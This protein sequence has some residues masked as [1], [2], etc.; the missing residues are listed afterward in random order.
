MVGE[1]GFTFMGENRIPDDIFK[2]AIEKAR[3]IEIATFE[4]KC[5]DTD[6]HTFSEKYL[7]RMQILK[8]GECEAND[9]KIV[10]YSV[11]KKSTKVKILLIAAIVMLLG[12]LT[13]T[14]E[15]VREVIYQLKEKIFPDNTEV[16]FQE[17]HANVET[18]NEGLTWKD[19]E[20]KKPAYIPSEYHSEVEELNESICEYLHIYVNDQ[21]KTITYEQKIIGAFDTWAISSDGDKAEIISINGERGYLFTDKKNYHTIV[22][23]SNG[24]VYSI[25]GFQDIDVLCKIVESI[26]KIKYTEIYPRKLIKVPDGYKLIVEEDSIEDF[27]LYQYMQIYQNEEGNNLVYQQNALDE[28]DENSLNITADGTPA[29][30]IAVCGEVAYLLTDYES[31]HT[32]IYARAGYLYMLGGYDEVDILI[33][34]LESVFEE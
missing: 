10:S 2:R 28:M 17:F 34:C 33:Q 13:V 7:E 24:Y 31:Y 16:S 9:S 27:G 21:G 32:I 22:Y 15:P 4:K 12:A 25:A 20:I 14:A 5:K 29:E 18:K 11:K 30:K 1:G 19:F 23:P 3:E 26:F 6:V 8:M